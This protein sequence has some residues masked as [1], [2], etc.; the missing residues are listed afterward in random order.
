MNSKPYYQDEWVTIYNS[1]CKEATMGTGKK[2]KIFP[3][4]YVLPSD[5]VVE[6]VKNANKPR[7]TIV[8]GYSIK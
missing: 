8:K 7:I 3:V 6:A 1:D 4:I 2:V 5:E